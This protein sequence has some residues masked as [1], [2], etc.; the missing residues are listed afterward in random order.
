MSRS[1]TWCLAWLAA[2]A[3]LQPWRALFGPATGLPARLEAAAA[4]AAGLAVG[5]LAWRLDR[6]RAVLLGASLVLAL[7][8][9]RLH[10]AGRAAVEALGE[11][12]AGAGAFLSRFW[13]EGA[14]PPGGVTAG[15]LTGAAA[16]ALGLLLA[17]A[18]RGRLRAEAAWAAVAAGFA[19]QW[20]QSPTG[21][22]SAPAFLLA[23]GAV[24]VL[25]AAGRGGGADGSALAAGILFAGLVT[26]LALTP[27][28]DRP[29]EPWPWLDRAAARV[30]PFAAG[31]QA[32][33]FGRFDAGSAGGPRL[34]GGPFR[35]DGRVLLTVTVEPGS[36]LVG[37][38]YLRGRVYGDYTGRAWR[39]GAPE[40]HVGPLPPLR[41]QV[42]DP[43]PLPVTVTVRPVALV[44]DVIYAPFV[45]VGVAAPRQVGWTR[46]LVLVSDAL[47]GRG[48]AVRVEARVPT[49]EPG[50]VDRPAGYA[51]PRWRGPAPPEADYLQLPP[52]LPGRV[53]R[54]AWS[55]AG[56]VGHRPYE[57]ARRPY[58]AA[59]RIEA[60]LR[61]LRYDPDFPP[62]APGQ[63]FVDVFLFERRA[64]Y[65]TAFA[66]AMTVMLRALGIP[67]RYVEGFVVP[68][69]GPGT[70]P[71]TGAQAH[72]WVEAYVW[73]YGWVPFEP[74]PVYPAAGER[75]AARGPGGGRQ[76]GDPAGR[77]TGPAADGAQAPPPGSPDGPAA[78][79]DRDP[80]R[81]AD[82]G[83]DRGAGDAGGRSWPWAAAALAAGAGAAAG[84]RRWRAARR[85]GPVPPAELRRRYAA[86]RRRLERALGGGGERWTALTPAEFAG[87]VARRW[88]ALAPVWGRLTAWYEQ[89]AYAP[90]PPAVDRR[91][92]RAWQEAW[93]RAWRARDG[94]PDS[95]GP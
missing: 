16:C 45:P 70:Y 55:V 53:R 1:A 69:S 15:I 19:L 79:P 43:D 71:V 73:G 95:A 10:P 72:A 67:A 7:A 11:P 51:V 23:T 74:T 83:P 38:L 14:P 12:L 26:V 29:A 34:L 92:W 42:V 28:R 54:L 48:D 46:D 30:F 32:P 40:P 3:A 86:A 90:R 9:A 21:E 63:D 82:P 24:W 84:V 85:D 5:A 31:G 27:P 52:G 78:R 33:G 77:V 47:L 44:G 2:L 22:V 81:G 57:A 76:P 37:P 41:S 61:G 88:P 35:P 17:G 25:A 94:S 93:R 39:P 89:A 20:G 59:R 62:L 13:R 6:R 87:A 49:P 64:G 50:E 80:P 56:D 91:A 68:A 75:G 36:V 8:A 18:A 66:S 60:Y 65:C 4:A 58:E